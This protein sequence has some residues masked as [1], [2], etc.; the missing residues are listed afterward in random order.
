MAD[1]DL[2][3]SENALLIVLMAEARAISNPELAERY[4]VR[5]IGKRRRKL[6]RLGF[7]ASERRGSPYFH[8]LDD[9]GWVR[10]QEAL[11]FDSPREA[12]ALGAA[13]AALHGNLR[14]RVLARTNFTSFTEMFARNGGEEQAPPVEQPGPQGPEAT[15][16]LKERIRTG[17][18]SLA[19]APGAWVILTR[20]RRLFPDVPKADFDQAL[21]ELSRASDVN[22]APESNQKILTAEDR[23]AAVRIG[24]QNK[25]LLAIGVR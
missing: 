8:Y 20:L 15:S 4:H 1:D 6:N 19:S 5:L 24:R 3:P 10:A 2:T 9:K 22:I 12:R 13:L 16:D 25:H 21:R 23:A 11:D 18:T 17:Y 7:V 14:D